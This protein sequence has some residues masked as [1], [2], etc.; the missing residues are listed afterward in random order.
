MKTHDEMI[1]VITAHKEGK[2]IE[3]RY[4]GCDKWFCSPS[5]IWDFSER[6]YRIDPR[7]ESELVP[8]WVA[9]Y[10]DP[11]KLFRI[12]STLYSTVPKGAVRLTTEHP[13]IMLPRRK[14]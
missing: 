9:L 5:P 3:C 8:H 13:P 11:D 6:E 2:K 4:K 1:A 10:L 14:E 12:G 7:D